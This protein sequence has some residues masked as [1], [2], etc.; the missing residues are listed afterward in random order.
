MAGD[1][2]SVLAAQLRLLL[3]DANVTTGE[4]LSTIR[5]RPFP[6]STGTGAAEI[7]EVLRLAGRYGVGVVSAGGQTTGIELCLDRW[8]RVLAVDREKL[9]L[10]VQPQAATRSVVDA[11]ADQGLCLPSDPCLKPCICADQDVIGGY[12]ATRVV[13]GLEAVLPD[14]STLVLGGP[15]GGDQLAMGLARLILGTGDLLG[16]I[17]SLHLRLGRLAP[18]QAIL[19]AVFAHVEE[20]RA[21]LFNLGQRADMAGVCMECLDLADKPAHGYV[22]AGEAMLI[23]EFAGGSPDEVEEAYSRVGTIC[24]EAGALEVLAA[25]NSAAMRRVKKLREY[26]LAPADRSQH[27]SHVSAPMQRD[28]PD[29]AAAGGL[30]VPYCRLEGGTLCLGLAGS[31]PALKRFV[32][33]L[34]RSVV[35]DEVLG[36]VVAGIGRILDPENVLTRASGQTHE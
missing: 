18:V 7:G 20:S 36:A 1:L 3:G 24:E 30:A 12:A 28:L 2:D 5:V 27:R 31:A 11:L 13:L 34:R 23:I 17:T 26:Y 33:G 32:A 9:C 10:T 14:G 15:S 8:N 22:T 19:L 16:V 21:A 4:G 6:P 35:G 25:D 29:L